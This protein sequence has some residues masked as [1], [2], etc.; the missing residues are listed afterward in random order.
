MPSYKDSKTGK[1]YCQ[2]YY[3]DELTGKNKHKVKRGFER[4]KDAD[5]WERKFKNSSHFTESILMDTLISEFIS[6][7]QTLQ[8]L[9]SIKLTTYHT[10]VNFIEI[11]ISPYFK[12]IIVTKI[13]TKDINNWLQQ[14]HAKKRKNLSSRT[15]NTAK[16]ILSQI[17]KFGI[18]NHNLADNPVDNAETIRFKSNDERAKYWSL[19]EYKK[20]Y[21]NIKQETYKVFFNLLYW[22]GLRLGEALALTPSD[23]Q[24][25]KININ[26][27]L[28]SINNK[29]YITTPKTETSI[30][31]VEITRNLYY[32]LSEYISHLYISDTDRIFELHAQAVRLYLY[33]SC[34]KLNLPKI[35][36]H[37][38][39]HSYASLLYNQSKNILVVSKQIGHKNPAITYEVYS[40]MLPEE[41]RKAIDKLENVEVKT[42]ETIEI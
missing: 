11:Y 19:D 30:R 33:E 21:D 13:K 5:A 1:W 39:R 15:I 4:K 31:T 6:H 37:I 22:S 12:D 29:E 3:R 40:H 24:P 7:L 28:V 18:I 2:F 42:V 35:S 8:K 16:N 20:F 25:Y 34:K 26:K 17:F 14:L 23:I 32:Q 41:D 9:N 27:N 10:K 36:P 38:L